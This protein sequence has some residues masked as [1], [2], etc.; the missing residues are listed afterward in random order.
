MQLNPLS[1]KQQ[2]CQNVLAAGNFATFSHFFATLD[3]TRSP[4]AGK[5][6][7]CLMPPTLAMLPTA[8]KHFDRA[9]AAPLQR[10]RFPHVCSPSIFHEADDF[11]T[12]M[13]CK[14]RLPSNIS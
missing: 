8:T 2:P 11:G 6:T 3:F 4:L 7:W 5:G 10:E 13:Y 9:E 14:M 12:N 1:Y